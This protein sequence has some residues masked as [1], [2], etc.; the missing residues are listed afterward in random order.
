MPEH[1]W[2]QEHTIEAELE[3]IACGATGQLL[4]KWQK[5]AIYKAIKQLKKLDKS[6]STIAE[7]AEWIKRQH[8]AILS[9]DEAISQLQNTLIE[10]A[11]GQDKCLE[12]I[13]QLENILQE[14]LRVAPSEITCDNLHHRKKDQHA[15]N[16]PCPI[17]IRYSETIENANK[18][19]QGE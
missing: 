7:Q 5:K 3:T 10:S 12:W 17:E 6:R 15:C 2:A 19:L 9:Q 4:Q 18:V 1:Y 13:K 8:D 16:E 11:V 14:V